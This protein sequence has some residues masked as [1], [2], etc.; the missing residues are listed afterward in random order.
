MKTNM[1]ELY[2]IAKQVKKEAEDCNIMIGEFLKS[3]PH[4][5]V[6]TV[7][8]TITNIEDIKTERAHFMRLHIAFYLEDQQRQINM[9]KALFYSN[10]VNSEYVMTMR[11]LLENFVPGE[12][13]NKSNLIGQVIDVEID[14]KAVDNGEIAVIKKIYGKHEKTIEEF[15]I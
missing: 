13:F 1:M 7:T 3:K 5:P 11:E 6:G 9:K 14:H 15:T 8:G 4:L 2:K 10:S 12:P